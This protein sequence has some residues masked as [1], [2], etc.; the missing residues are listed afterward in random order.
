MKVV[1][2]EQ[3]ISGFKNKGKKTAIHTTIIF[4][5]I[6]S[7]KTKLS[8][9]VICFYIFYVIPLGGLNIDVIIFFGYL[10]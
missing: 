1:K 2:I 7:N 5:I 6:I 3:A 8:T 9:S 10:I 4:M